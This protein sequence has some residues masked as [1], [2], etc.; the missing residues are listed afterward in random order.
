M[1]QLVLNAPFDMRLCEVDMPERSPEDVLLRVRAAGICGSDV[2]AYRG[3]QPF[4]TYPRIL[5]H[6]LGCEIA[7]IE[8]GD[9]GFN[10]GDAVVV[11]PY[12]G[13]GRC[14]PCMIGRYNCCS[15]LQVMGVHADG[16]MRDYFAVPV[17]YLH[18]APEG[19]SFEELAMVET[20]AVGAHGVKRARVEAGEIVA[21]VGAGP[22]GIGA[23]QYA[24]SLGARTI[25]IDI[26]PQSLEK[27][28]SLGADDVIDS[29][30]SDP[31]EE[32]MKL[33]SGFG[34]HAVV[35]CVGKPVTIE[36]TVN[37]VAP[38]GRIAIVG[39]GDQ[40]VSFP[41]QVFNKKEI[42]Y[43]GV[44]NARDMF[45]EI[46]ALMQEGAISMAPLVTQ[47]F[48]IDEGVEAFKFVHE[49]Q[50]DVRKAVILFD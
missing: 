24:K 35:E 16:G 1:R 30:S 33:T 25:V 13:C 48:N 32:L 3:H 49:N 29:S 45:P 50:Q 42:D 40:K 41:Q 39:V 37:L 34:A 17:K 23:M 20:T 12:M 26:A 4:L 22:I 6:E 43:F 27:A 10:V 14:Y 38:A 28:K 46:I 36:M 31:V 18:K 11:E 9:H 5:G 21:I 47:R 15:R 19:S 44:R 2:H 7:E 8:T